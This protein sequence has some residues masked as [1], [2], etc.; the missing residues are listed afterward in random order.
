VIPNFAN[1]SQDAKENTT[2]VT[3]KMIRGQLEL[4]KVQHNG[5]YPDL[6]NSGQ[7]YWNIM[8]SKSTAT[9]VGPAAGSATGEFG[10]YFR[11]IPVNPLNGLSSV[12]GISAGNPAGWRYDS[13]TGEIK[14]TDKTGS[15]NLS[16]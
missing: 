13:T 2:K 5:K 10:P 1:A 14:A 11:D 16:Y 12:S 4:F 8:M 15:G 9:Q 6:G 3:L 7:G